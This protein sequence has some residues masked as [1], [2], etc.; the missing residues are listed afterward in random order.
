MTDRRSEASL[1]ARPRLLE[2]YRRFLPVTDATPALTLGEGFTP[3][4]HAPRLGA[5]IG[6]PNLYLK[7]EGQNPTG[8]FKDRGMVMAVAKAIERGARAIVCASTGN[9]SASAAAYGAAA[10][11][12]VIVILPRGQIALGKLLQALVAGARVVAV[13]GNFD[14]ALDIV[15]RLA[16]QDDHPVTLVN[17]V[18]PF[19]IEGQKTGAFEICDDLGRAPDVLA[20][21]VGNAGNITAY[22]AGFKEYAAVG[23]VGSTPAMWGFQAAGAAPIVQG[24]RVDRPETVATAIRIGNPASWERAVAARDESGGGIEA[25]TDEEIL[26]AY[27]DLPRLTGIFCE[28][29]SAASIAGVRKMAASG[30]IDP[31]ATV[32]AVLTGHGLKDPDTAGTQVPGVIESAPTLGA[33]AVALG[34]T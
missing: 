12:E 21:P 32:V 17:S 6:A 16:E 8:S 5:A 13:D 10:G 11:L 14:Q 18:N 29:A 26:A 28:P 27:R 3:L 9:T 22:W 33:V 2:R 30:R 20:I 1:Q 24:R 15:R 23:M 4:V 7:F 19:R 31:D 34:W 25:V